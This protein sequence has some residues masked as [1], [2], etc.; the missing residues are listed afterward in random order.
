MSN[1]RDFYSELTIMQ[2]EAFIS[3]TENQVEEEYLM[4]YEIMTTP[5][6]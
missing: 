3:Y 4:M 6:F 2:D 1:Q 5:W